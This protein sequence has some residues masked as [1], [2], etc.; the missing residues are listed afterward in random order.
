M[1]GERRDNIRRKAG[2]FLRVVEDMKSIV[3]SSDYQM[4]E[5]KETRTARFAVVVNVIDVIG[6]ICGL[7][8][9]KIGGFRGFKIT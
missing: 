1:R 9:F 7:S 8:D 2:W 4:T 3:F 5:L 6:D